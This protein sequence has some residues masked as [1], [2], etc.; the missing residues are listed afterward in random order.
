MMMM[1]NS[2]NRMKRMMRK[3]R[4][5]CKK[6]KKGTKRKKRK[7]KRK[8]RETS[9]NVHKETINNLDLGIDAVCFLA[10]LFLCLALMVANWFQCHLRLYPL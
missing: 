1:K 5:T 2:K 3:K 9:K 4:K 10:C 6:G 7:K 8:Q